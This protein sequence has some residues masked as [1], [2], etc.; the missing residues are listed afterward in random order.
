MYKRIA[1]IGTGG[2]GGLLGGFLAKGN[3]E[4]TLIDQGS[5][6][7]YLREHG[8]T[9]KSDT[10]GTWTVRPKQVV[11]A[12]A[13]AGDQDIVFICVKNF[14]LDALAESIKKDIRPGTFILPVM[15]GTD[16]P[17]RLR[18]ILPQA[19]VGEAVIYVVSFID[20]DGNIRQV[21][22]RG[23]ILRIGMEEATPEDREVLE[24]IDSMFAGAGI[25]HSIETDI[26]RAVWRKY[27][28]NCAF[29]VT[30]A[31]YD[32]PIGEVAKNPERLEEYRN[33]V[34]EAYA[35]GRS[36]GVA[37]EEEDKRPA[38]KSPVQASPEETS[39]LMRDLHDGRPSELEIFGG[40]IVREGHRNGVPVPVSE[41]FYEGLKARMNG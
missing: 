1:I 15:N 20:R 18:R 14:S 16:A 33:L 39:T 40:Y 23:A 4:V 5:R 10:Y 28:L 11:S 6:V 27:M 7:D 26:R 31:F 41:R 22:K 35:V 38:L 36:L 13:E 8:L 2:I 30:T 25:E 37:L 9:V 24:E 34:D 3:P 32:C 12:L 19:R 21:G 17:E 29:N